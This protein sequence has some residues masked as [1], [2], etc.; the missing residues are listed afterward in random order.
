MK[1]LRPFLMRMTYLLPLLMVLL[2]S[3]SFAQVFTVFTPDAK[4]FPTIEAFYDAK[5]ASGNPI[6]GLTK[7]DF[8]I[9]ENGVK[10]DPSLVI[11]RCSTIVDGPT[12]CIVLVI[13]KSNSMGEI[14]DGTNT[15]RFQFVKDAA[16]DFVNGLDYKKKTSVAI[17]SFDGEAYWESDWSQEKGVLMDRIDKITLG[18]VTRY[19]QPL[20]DNRWGAFQLLKNQNCEPP[21]KRIIIFLTDGN[22]TP[23]GPVDSLI[24]K[25]LS[26]LGAIFYAI[27]AFN[28]MNSH[29]QLWSDKTGGKA[30]VADGA[31][32][33]SKLLEIYRR[34]AAE[35]QGKEQC[36]LRWTA[37]LSC[38]EGGRK[39]NVEIKLKSIYNLTRTTSYTAPANSVLK[40]A[41][42]P[43]VA[44]FGDPDPNMPQTVTVTVTASTG[45]ITLTK[46]SIVSSG[47]TFTIDDWDGSSPITIDS[48]KSR[49]FK[50]TFTQSD[51]K[52]FRQ[53]TFLIKG[54]PCDPPLISLVAGLSQVVLLAPGK[55]PSDTLQSSCEDMIIKWAGVKPEDSVLIQ[56]SDDGGV[57]WKLLKEN[58]TGLSYTWP[59]S[60]I[61]K[62]NKDGKF[63]IKILIPST[64]QIIWAKSG[65]G[66]QD[67]STSSISLSDDGLYAYVSGSYQGTNANFGGQ[68]LTSAGGSVDGFLAQYDAQGNVVWVTGF[69]G[70]GEDRAM[71]AV[72]APGG[73][74]FVTGFYTGNAVFG[75]STMN[76]LDKN[77]RNYFLARVQPSGTIPFV[78]DGTKSKVGFTGESYGVEVAYVPS[79]NRIYVHGKF[80]GRI[81]DPNLG[82]TIASTNPNQFDDFTAIHDYNGTLLNLIKTYQNQPYTKL[83][84]TDK[85]GCLYETGKFSTPITKGAFNLTSAGGTDYFISKFCGLPASSDA[86]AYNITLG[87]PLMVTNGPNIRYDLKTKAGVGNTITEKLGTSLC[88]YGTLSTEIDSVVFSNTEFSADNELKGLE[89]I[90]P[91][92]ANFDVFIN[93]SPKTLLPN[94]HCTDVTFYAK[95]AEPVKITVCAEAADECTF[96]KK[97]A[98]FTP[99]LVGSNNDMLIT[100]MLC[101]TSKITQFSGRFD[102]TGA[103]PGDFEVI[104][105][106]DDAG[107][108]FAPTGTFTLRAGRCLTIT[109]RFKPS[110]AGPRSALLEYRIDST[111]GFA[112][113]IL[114]GNGLAPL[115]LEVEPQTWT[116]TRPGTKVQQTLNVKNIGTGDATVTKLSLQTGTAFTIISPTPPITI[117]AG[118]SFPVTIEYNPP[119]VGV[120]NDVLNVDASSTGGSKVFSNTLTGQG[121]LPVVNLSK[122]CFPLTALGGSSVIPNAIV[123]TNTGNAPLN[124]TSIANNG[125]FTTF[126]PNNFTI[127]PNKSQDIQATF[128][129]SV[130]G[131]TTAFIRIISDGV[132]GLDSIEVCG[133]AFA[134]DTTLDFGSVLLCEGPVRTVTYS[135]VSPV[136][137]DIDVISDKSNFTVTPSGKVTVAANSS[138]SFI[139]VFQ[140]DKV[141]A[142]SGTVKVG[143]K[144]VQV[145]GEGKIAPIDF[146][147][148]PDSASSTRLN[149]ADIAKITVKAN[150][151]GNLDNS[152][153]NTLKFTFTFPKKLFGLATFSPTEQI[154]TLL[155]G[156][157]WTPSMLD[158]GT[159]LVMTVDGTGPSITTAQ[160]NKDLFNLRLHAYLGDTLMYPIAVKG[161]V[162]SRLS[163]C[164]PTTSKGTLFEMANICFRAGRLISTSNTVYQ[165]QA[166]K[167]TPASNEAKFEYGIGL[168]GM[169]EITLHNSLGE[170]IQTLVREHQESGTYEITLNVSTLPAGVYFYVIRSGPYMEQQRLYIAK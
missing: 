85:D 67:D 41:V 155:P 157:T 111:C 82:I 128:T 71:G 102:L 89:F 23:P 94:P 170:Q 147:V 75:S 77:V 108:V 37:P 112:K 117:I 68:Q 4:K 161:S 32:A 133:S 125:V 80:K 100:Q 27:T 13:D 73:I 121:C 103:N 156:W 90:V 58:A 19:E 7:N 149:P 160:N 33:G 105:V 78:Y 34:I 136:P 110:S 107:V 54:T 16:K 5:D 98:D 113:S 1:S 24:L 83:S 15:T 9:V 11:Q 53:G 25:G 151:L 55:L 141:G 30:F 104:D 164:V 116:C 93:F 79:Q 165:L 43:P 20:L 62:M 158:V 169:T 59:R 114:T 115:A 126:T 28:G 31:D 61:E 109:V 26:D 120:H 12:L 69:G 87:K 153:L 122:N 60:E 70:S 66:V 97:D 146:F 47:G 96:T 74:T 14:V 144:N 17:V 162:P 22:P 154:E 45:K 49:S 92:C 39:R 127:A 129:P 6:Q 84:A 166:P 140:P 101:N 130:V 35:L 142:F 48:G 57:T 44:Y 152:N 51:P 131:N 63:R 124:V 64:K 106:K 38:D 18:S 81:N 168:S 36:Y 8:D 52:A 150:I 86:S 29:L 99:T 42:N 119:A 10:I 145:K 123:V 118:G 139:V 163:L 88:N 148:T 167:P 46:G 72:S 135:N 134:A 132:P 40:I 76:P 56:Y 65:G 95:C 91:N 159:N 138:E 143:P 21:A 3:S 50:I 2:F 137:V